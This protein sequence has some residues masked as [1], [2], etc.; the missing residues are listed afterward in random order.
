MR[1]LGVV[2]RLRQVFVSNPRE[3]IW[4]N[5]F[6]H[7]VV[8]AVF[9]FG[10]QVMAGQSQVRVGEPRLALHSALLG[11][12]RGVARAAARGFTPLRIRVA[13]AVLIAPQVRRAVHETLA[14]RLTGLLTGLLWRRLGG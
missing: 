9:G 1:R 3:N 5:A 7:A 11:L 6:G 13:L 12:R 14:H 8:A 10:H 2:L 4:V